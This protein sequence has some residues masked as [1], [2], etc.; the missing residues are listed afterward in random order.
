M[1]PSR[2]P[3]AVVVVP[4]LWG[5]GATKE[6]LLYRGM[7]KL[8][9]RGCNITAMFT[10]SL[11]GRSNFGRGVRVVPPPKTV[12]QSFKLWFEA[13]TLELF[14]AL[15]AALRA[16]LFSSRT[17]HSEVLSCRHSFSAII[18]RCGATFLLIVCPRVSTCAHIV[19]CP[20]CLLFIFKEP[21]KASQKP[22]V[23]R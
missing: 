9:R 2:R 11:F 21:P 1:A 15:R 5:H 7:Q 23:P 14:L 13:K 18:L 3:D 16:E 17:W 12:D 8:L 6:Y 22:S 10:R 19:R 20:C 4:Q